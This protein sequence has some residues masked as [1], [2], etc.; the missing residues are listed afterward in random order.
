M[1]L[2]NKHAY[3]N[4]EHDLIKVPELKKLLQQNLVQRQNSGFLLGNITIA[5][6][7]NPIKHH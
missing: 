4:I 7:K 2:E 5:I 1:Y 3:F 6:E